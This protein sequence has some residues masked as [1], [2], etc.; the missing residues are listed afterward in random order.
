MKLDGDDFTE[1]YGLGVW[2]EPGGVYR[3]HGAYGQLAVIDPARRA[4]VTVTAHTERE[5]EQLA[6]VHELVLDRLG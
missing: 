3:M 2:L 5:N 6:A 4:T 1:G